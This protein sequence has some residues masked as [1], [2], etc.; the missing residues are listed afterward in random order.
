MASCSN[1]ENQPMKD[2]MDFFRYLIILLAETGKKLKINC[3]HQ[4]VK[5][6]KAASSNGSLLQNLL[7]VK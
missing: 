3:K 2:S 6:T 5:M 7:E 1:M 4:N